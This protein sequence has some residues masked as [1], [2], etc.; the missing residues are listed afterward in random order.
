[1][2]KVVRVYWDSCA[3]LGLLNGE[4]EKKRELEIVYTNARNGHCELWTS[5]LSM[6]EV[7]RLK[8]EQYDP[9]PLKADH[10]KLIANLF[11]QPFIKPVPLSVDIADRARELWRTAEGLNKWQDS[12]HLASAL[13]W[14][15]DVLHTYDQDDLL[16]LSMLLECR[17]GEK[18]NICYLNETT[19]GP[20]F[21]RRNK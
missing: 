16:H 18:L 17:N 21:V 20:L 9:K 19:D 1:M 6:V 10:L 2:A 3:W 8:L 5:T 11:R 14:N 7:R 15:V 4:V 12:I 13:H